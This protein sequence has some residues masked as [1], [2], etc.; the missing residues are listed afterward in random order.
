[1]FISK[2]ILA[3]V[4]SLLGILALEAFAETV[5]APIEERDLAAW[6]I[7]IP[8]DGAGLPA[9]KG[10]VTQGAVVYAEQCAACHGEVGTDGPAGALVGGLG[11]L[12]TNQPVKTVGSYWPYATTL[13]D[14]VR[15]AMPYYAPGSLSDGEAY[16]VTAYLLHLN[17]IVP[18]QTVLD[19]ESLPRVE[20]PNRQ[21]FISYWRSPN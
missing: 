7:S 19:A 9:G 6:E 21:G 14:Y 20:M 15:R 3:F 11:T 2:L 13:F 17:G 10:S 18:E 5:G 8:P 12:S 1:M 16:A 4:G